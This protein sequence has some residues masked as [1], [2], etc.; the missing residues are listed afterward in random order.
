M[1][2]LAL[3]GCPRYVPLAAQDIPTG[4]T[5]G[6]GYASGFEG[7]A[8]HGEM[9]L[10]FAHDGLGLEP[11]LSLTEAFA[12]DVPSTGGGFI[13]GCPDPCLQRVDREQMVAAGMALTYRTVARGLD[14]HA[15]TFVQT[16]LPLW[17][18][19]GYRAGLEVGG[20]TPVGP[21]NIGADIQVARFTDDESRIP[22]LSVTP[23]LRAA[24]DW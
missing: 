23:V 22:A 18:R 12:F 24:L 10:R 19:R 9:R 1:R 14:V 4:L 13:G 16:V 3:L 17:S 21:F 7:G 20:A 5:L 6:A 2:R 8:A 15:G 11:T